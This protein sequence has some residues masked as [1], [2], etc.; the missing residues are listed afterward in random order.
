[1]SS[2]AHD[3]TTDLP[4]RTVRSFGLLMALVLGLV[5]AWRAWVHGSGWWPWLVASAVMALL[6][7]AWPAS[8]R[9]PAR[10]WMKFAELLHAVV[11]PLLMALL[12]VLAVIP[13]GLLMRVM[14]RDPMRRSRDAG[15]T[16]YWI[17][18]EGA[19]ETPGTMNDQF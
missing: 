17:S 11:N 5:C 19:R 6:A 14:G 12:F 18:R 1:M 13:T 9:G 3:P 7:L 8:L 15:A 4:P 10:L 2:P 16:T